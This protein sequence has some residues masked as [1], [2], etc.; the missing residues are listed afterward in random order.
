MPRYPQSN[1][2][3]EA[4]NKIIINSLNERLEVV[5]GR[6]VEEL[7]GVLWAN[8]TTPKSAISEPP[9]SLVY[10]AEDVIPTEVLFSMLRARDES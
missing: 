5:K 9:Y 1:W 2:Q 3:T 8:H 4:S 6:W 10:G 7:S